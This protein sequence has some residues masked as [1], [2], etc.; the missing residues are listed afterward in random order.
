ML[1]IVTLWLNLYGCN[2]ALHPPLLPSRGPRIIHINELIL[3][4]EMNV[5][6]ISHVRLRVQLPL[7]IALLL[8]Q[9]SFPDDTGASTVLPNIC[10]GLDV[11]EYSYR[12][13]LLKHLTVS[14]PRSKPTEFN[15]VQD[16]TSSDA[17]DIFGRVRCDEHLSPDR[18]A[19]TVRDEKDCGGHCLFRPSSDVGWEECPDHWRTVSVVV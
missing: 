18:I 11:S 6:K 9:A 5:L 16:R 2:C 8:G 17:P 10:V 19:D 14:T 12:Q 1:V 4:L 13:D 3:I 15:D 7:S